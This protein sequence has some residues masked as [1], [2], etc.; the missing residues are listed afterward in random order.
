[1]GPA[2]VAAQLPSCLLYSRVPDYVLQ[3][4]GVEG[5]SVVYTVAPGQRAHFLL[6]WIMLLSGGSFCCLG[7]CVGTLKVCPGV[8]CHVCACALACHCCKLHVPVQLALWLRMWGGCWYL[9]RTSTAVG[10]GVWACV[11]VLVWVG[12]WQCLGVLL[13]A[14]ST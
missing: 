2:C 10:V 8:C 7:P 4:P 5:H 14:R 12:G 1:M 6:S 9:E 11:G 3:V 13:I